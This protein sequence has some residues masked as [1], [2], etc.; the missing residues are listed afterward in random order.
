MNYAEVNAKTGEGIDD[1]FNR[2][3]KAVLS[4]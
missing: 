1:L 4:G 3:I 2:I